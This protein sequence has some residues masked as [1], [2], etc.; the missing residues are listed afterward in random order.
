MKKLIILLLSLLYVINAYSQTNWPPIGAQWY[1]SYTPCNI[2]Y[3]P[4]ID[5]YLYLE[6]VKDTTINDTACK[7]IIVEYHSIDNN[8]EQLGYELIHATENQVYNFHH[9]HFYLLYDYSLGIDDTID[10]YL[11]SN[12]DLYRKLDTDVNMDTTYKKHVVTEKDSVLI[13]GQKKLFIKMD[14][15]YEEKDGFWFLY[16]ARR[17]IKGIG[18]ELFLLGYLH[19]PFEADYYGPLRCYIDSSTTYKTVSRC[20]TLITGKENVAADEKGIII[21]P[22]PAKNHLKIDGGGVSIEGLKYNIIS[23]TGKVLLNGFIQPGNI[24]DVSSLASGIYYLKIVGDD[25]DLRGKFVKQ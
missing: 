19:A 6:Y 16:H 25:N 12:S 1:Y 3:C 4:N 18:S 21:Y 22:C 8:I 5:E 10:L 14:H 9:G 17:I 7:K 24:I 2:D 13:N 11:G 23:N 15:V 20:D